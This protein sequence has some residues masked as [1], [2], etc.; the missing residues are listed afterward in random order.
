MGFQKGPVAA[1]LVGAAAEQCDSAGRAA[2][3]H[4]GDGGLRLGPREACQ[5]A[6][7]VLLPADLLVEIGAQQ[8]GHRPQLPEPDAHTLLADAAGP[9]A[10]DQHPLAVVARGRLV[11]ALGPDVHVRLAACQ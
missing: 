2:S 6:R 9:E 8:L 1:C 11:D 4:L 10:H 3:L 5:V 7:H